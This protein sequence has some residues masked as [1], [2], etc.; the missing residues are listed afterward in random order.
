MMLSDEEI[1][2]IERNTVSQKDNDQWRIQ[3]KSRLTASNFGKLC[4]L[5]LTTS[6]ANTAKYIPYDIFQENSATRYVF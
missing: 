1:L 2:A 5:R 3:R 4:K 6:R